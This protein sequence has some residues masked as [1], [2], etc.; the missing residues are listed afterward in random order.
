MWT[1]P[2]SDNGHWRF[3]HD[4]GCSGAVKHLQSVENENKTTNWDESVG[5]LLPDIVYPSR[6]RSSTELRCVSAPSTISFIRLL[7]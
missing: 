7:V 2:P 1:G 3:Q 5:K 6:D 4:L